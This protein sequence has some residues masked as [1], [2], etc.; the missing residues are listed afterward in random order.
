MINVI[1]FIGWVLSVGAAISMAVPF[2]FFW[3]VNHVGKTF[4]YF[5]PAVYQAPGFW[6]TVM[7]FVVVS[8]IKSIFLPSL[9]ST[10][11]VNK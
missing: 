7:L 11:K 9:G 1:P 8:I 3:T 5:L 2:W 6:D 10:V 4:F